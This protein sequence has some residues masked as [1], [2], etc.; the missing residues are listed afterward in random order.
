MAAMKVVLMTIQ[1][2]TVQSIILITYRKQALCNLR[3]RVNNNCFTLETGK[4]KLDCA[5]QCHSKPAC[6]D[7]VFSS[8]DLSCYLNSSCIFTPSCSIFDSD[9][10]FYT[11]ELQ[12]ANTPLQATAPTTETTRGLSETSSAIAETTAAQTETTAAPTE[13]TAAPTETTTAPPETTKTSTTTLR[14]TTT[15]C[16]HAGSPHESFLCNVANSLR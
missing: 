3:D 7:F 5:L 11:S 4:T 10:T 6:K 1:L 2:I 8:Q 14:S 15:E 12:A 13:T 9:L 16:F